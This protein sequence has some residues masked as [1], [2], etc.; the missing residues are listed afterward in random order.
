MNLYFILTV[1]KQINEVVVVMIS[2]THIQ[3]YVFMMLL[4]TKEKNRKLIDFIGAEL[5]L[6]SDDS[7]NSE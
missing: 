4:K 1:L 6:E 5:E 7:D 2:M 3:N